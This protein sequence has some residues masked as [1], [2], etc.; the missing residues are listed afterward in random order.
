[1]VSRERVGLFEFIALKIY[2]Q[3]GIG[4]HAKYMKL[5]MQVTNKIITPSMSYYICHKLSNLGKKS[6]ISFVLACCFNDLV[7]TIFP[8]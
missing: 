4:T 1:V 5:V 2:L 3:S 7:A 8:L 6:E